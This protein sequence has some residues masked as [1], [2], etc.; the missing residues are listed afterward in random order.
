MAR[1]WLLW[2]A[3][4]SALQWTHFLSLRCAGGGLRPGLD[5]PPLG[6][7]G[8]IAQGDC[9]GGEQERHF[10]Q[11]AGLGVWWASPVQGVQL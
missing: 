10:L 1:W 9:G 3:G 7:G 2:G 5:D 8:E 11:E 4:S 6:V